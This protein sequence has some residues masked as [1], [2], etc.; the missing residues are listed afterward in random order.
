[1]MNTVMIKNTMK[2]PLPMAFL[3]QTAFFSVEWDCSCIGSSSLKNF[4]QLPVD[5]PY[6]SCS[7]FQHFGPVIHQAGQIHCIQ[8]VQ[9]FILEH[10]RLF[11]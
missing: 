11:S 10:G 7:G 3:V 6:R 9:H 2:I 4:Q 1:M 8:R 5:E